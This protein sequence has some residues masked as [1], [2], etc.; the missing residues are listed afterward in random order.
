MVFFSSHSQSA[1]KKSERHGRA[2]G[3]SAPVGDGATA[4]IHQDEI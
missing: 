3:G 2:S 4:L 1:A